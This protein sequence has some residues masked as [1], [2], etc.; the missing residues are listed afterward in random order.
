MITSLNNR[1]N[2][3]DVT[4]ESKVGRKDF[5]VHFGYSANSLD[6]D[7]FNLDWRYLVSRLGP[8]A[9]LFKVSRLILYYRT[10]LGPPLGG[11]LYAHLG[12]RSPFILGIIF[13]FID[14]MGRILIIEKRRS[15]QG[16]SN[17]QPVDEE[18][19]EVNGPCSTQTSP[20]LPPEPLAS[21]KN[22]KFTR[23]L[24]LLLK[25][26]RAIVAGAI[27]IGYGYAHLR[28]LRY[29]Y[30]LTRSNSSRILT[31]LQDTILTMHLN[32]VWGLTS[33]RVGVVMLAAVIP[34][35]FGM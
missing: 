17:S 12:F 6:V 2:R 26:P 18:K 28:F 7:Q 14:L 13:A 34:T 10:L 22:V 5:A 23:V 24:L 15:A 11:A 33:E 29:T 16:S 30:I 35:I 31:G 25:S 27:G 21:P 19:A 3:C 1:S 8:Y 32:D 20:I 9:V 4:P